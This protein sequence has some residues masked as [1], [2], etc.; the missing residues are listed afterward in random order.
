MVSTLGHGIL[1][2]LNDITQP[3]LDLAQRVDAWDVE[4]SRSLNWSELEEDLSGETMGRKSRTHGG[5][6]WITMDYWR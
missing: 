5:L 1:P 3:L 2:K 6:P 4:H